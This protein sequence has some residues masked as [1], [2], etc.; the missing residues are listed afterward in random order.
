M[1]CYRALTLADSVD[2]YALYRRCRR[3][4][5]E[6]DEVT[7]EEFIHATFG[8][9]G[10]YA[11]RDSVAAIDPDGR[12]VGFGWAYSRESATR[13]ARAWLTGG[14]D[15]ERR[16]QGI[17]TVILRRG[18]ARGI[19]LLAGAPATV[20]HHV[21]AEAGPEHADRIRLFETF[22]LDRVRTFTAMVVTPADA[23]DTVL[24]R[25]ATDTPFHVIDWQPDVD[26]ATR[27]AHNEAFRDHWGSEP[28]SAERWRH[29][30]PA[31]PGFRPDL[32]P[33]AIAPDGRVAGYVL[34]T[35]PPGMQAQRRTAWIGTVG[36]RREFRRHGLGR[37]LLVRTL[38]A[39]EEAGFAAVGLDVDADNPTGAVRVY[40]RLGFRPTRSQHIYSKVVPA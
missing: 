18:L 38:A 27:T 37:A 11:E 21:D 16:R 23:P 24:D 3:A 9:P 20:P 10:S 12:L 31:A 22:G 33:I 4:D 5:A 8:L 2:L 15:P 1:S 28:V 14:V 7:F 29:L 30:G 19:E 13:S 40:E 25:P 39:A 32:S 17:G 36:V 26:E 35:I 6:P 34:C